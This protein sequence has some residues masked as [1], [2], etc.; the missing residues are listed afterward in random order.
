MMFLLSIKFVLQSKIVLQNLLP[1]T[2]N[3]W[4]N[5]LIQFI[6][7]LDTKSHN[8]HNICISTKHP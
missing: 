7:V 5:C 2:F 4:Y 3:I 1:M 6:Y 8:K